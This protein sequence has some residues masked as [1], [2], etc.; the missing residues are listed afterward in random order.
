M[1]ELVENMTCLNAFEG[2]ITKS[3]QKVETDEKIIQKVMID[4][5]SWKSRKINQKVM[6]DEKG[7]RTW[8]S[9]QKN[10]MNEELVQKNEKFV[11]NSVMNAQI[12]SKVVMDPSMFKNGGL[13][14]LQPRNQ[15]MND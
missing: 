5:K 12:D 6:T 7:W 2:K 4:E 8:K 3:N 14:S 13:N 9:N 15:T 10:V 1:N 11:K